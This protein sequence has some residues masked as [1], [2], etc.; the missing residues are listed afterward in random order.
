MQLDLFRDFK[1]PATIVVFPLCRQPVAR[2]LATDLAHMEFDQGKR[3]WQSTCRSL[4]SDLRRR[5]LSTSAIR[6][7]I[8]Q[9]ADAVHEELKV[10]RSQK[11]FRMTAIVIPLSVKRKPTFPHGYSVGEASACDP[12]SQ[13]LARPEGT[14]YDAAHAREGGAT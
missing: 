2:S 9:L 6:M 13:T 10:V 14:E 7:E 12:R 8:D 5:G 11:H 1:A 3:H 4:R